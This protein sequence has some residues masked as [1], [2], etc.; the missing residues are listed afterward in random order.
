M[1]F[2]LKALASALLLSTAAFGVAID[3]AEHLV[4]RAQPKGIDVSSNQGSINW[5]DV[6]A[7]GNSF[8]YIKATEGTSKTDGVLVVQ[9]AEISLQPTRTL[10]FPPSILVPPVPVSFGVAITSL[11]PI[12]PLGLLRPNISP[13]MVEA[14]VAMAELSRVPSTSNVRIVYFQPPLKN[15]QLNIQNLSDR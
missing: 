3:S 11:A 15:R 13:L 7:K 8:A 10:T 12:S 6:A 4:K 1:L 9:S 2:S 5:K 14:G